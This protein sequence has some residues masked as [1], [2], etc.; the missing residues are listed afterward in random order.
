MGYQS[1]P[2]QQGDSHSFAKLASL[3]LP[4]LKG[5]S[6][7][8]VGCNTGYFCGW[9]VFDKSI[10][11]MGIDNNPEAIALA[12]TWFQGCS[13]LCMSWENLP[14]DRFDVVLCLS[15]IHYADDQKALIDTLMERV[16]PGGTLVLELGIAPGEEDTFETV[17]RSI[18]IRKFPTKKKLHSML[19]NYAFKFISA[20]VQQ[21][22]DPIPRS[23]LHIRHKLPVAVLLM[24]DHYS[25]KST[26]VEAVIKPE[27]PRIH[28]DSLYANVVSAKYTFQMPCDK[29]YSQK[30]TQTD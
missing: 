23:V 13:F 19:S 17:Q 7:L 28:G 5:K 2:W 22:G 11:V 29:K 24:D 20:S 4:S 3:H 8:D 12:K 21:A 26:L 27:L 15:A 14:P 6:L 9:A 16:A 10:R 30:Q 1:L 25:G 18:D